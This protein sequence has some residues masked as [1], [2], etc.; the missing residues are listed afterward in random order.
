QSARIR[1]RFVTDNGNS[2]TT[3]GWYID[4]IKLINGCM[5]E[6]AIGIYDSTVLLGNNSAV[7]FVQ[8]A[9]FAS[10]DIINLIATKIAT[11]Q[12]VSITWQT[13]HEINVSKYEVERSTD[14]ITWV[15]IGSV[16]STGISGSYNIIDSMPVITGN[17]YYRLKIDATDSSIIY[18][19]EKTV[20][21]NTSAIILQPNPA[22]DYVN[23]VLNVSI[24]SGIPIRI[25]DGTGKLVKEQIIT[26]GK[27]RISTSE[28]ASG[29]Y[30][31]S[32]ANPGNLHTEKLLIQH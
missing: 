26:S 11:E 32:V 25:Y 4:D 20:G 18:S 15:V 8:K 24:L 21:F 31:I 16:I 2:V 22:S 14:Q 3:E 13:Q 17:N 1:F 28:L 29:V 5:V 6:N 7:T 23:I 27:N 30:Y 19:N 10:V 9:P 12:K